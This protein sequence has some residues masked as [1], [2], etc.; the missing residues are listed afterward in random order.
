MRE[1][2]VPG[3]VGGFLHN[4]YSRLTKIL[5]A[6]HLGGE[7][8][9]VEMRLEARLPRA[10]FALLPGHRQAHGTPHRQYLS[11]RKFVGGYHVQSHLTRCGR[12]LRRS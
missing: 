12:Q 2:N 4:S 7:Q 11:G 10:E 1:K 8:A 9:S 3:T 6:N 5:G